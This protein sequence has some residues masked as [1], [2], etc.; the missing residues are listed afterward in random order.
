[1]PLI[2][3]AIECW[4]KCAFIIN[5]CESQFYQYYILL[6]DNII[7]LSNTPA[8]FTQLLTK[9]LMQFKCRNAAYLQWDAHWD[10]KTF[11]NN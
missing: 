10:A 7:T 9:L 2:W 11:G 3:Y 5:D 8:G 4:L 1:M 6:V